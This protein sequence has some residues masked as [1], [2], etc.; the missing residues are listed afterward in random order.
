MRS[1]KDQQYQ[2]VFHWFFA[3]VA[4]LLALVRVVLVV[5]TKGIYREKNNPPTFGNGKSNSNNKFTKS[6]DYPDY[7]YF[8]QH[9]RS[10]QQVPLP[11]PLVLHRYFFSGA[12]G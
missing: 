1:F 9:R 12:H 2:H 4:S 8:A 7:W 3:G 11:K 5:P 10:F 6:R